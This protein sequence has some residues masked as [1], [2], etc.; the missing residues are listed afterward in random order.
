[1]TFG[2]ICTYNSISSIPA[3]VKCVFRAHSNKIA[4]IFMFCHKMS[5]FFRLVFK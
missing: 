1:M 5:I 3:P 4:F 2:C